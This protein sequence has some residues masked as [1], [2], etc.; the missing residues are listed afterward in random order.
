MRTENRARGKGV[1]TIRGRTGGVGGTPQRSVAQIV[2][3]VVVNP[4][5]AVLSA[6]GLKQQ[7][8]AVAQDANGKPVAGQVFTWSSSL[9]AIASVDQN[10]LATGLAIGSALITAATAG[11]TGSATL[12]IAQTV[13]SVVVSP[14]TAAL[15]AL[16]GTQQLTATAKDASG[17]VI[18]GRSFPWK[19]DNPLVAPVDAG[20]VVKAVGNGTATITATTAGGS[21]D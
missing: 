7:F 6:L 11:V 12:S 9:P 20:G 1:A 13:G 18:P 14:A 17:N 4:A 5:S 2:R 19:S 15:D 10:G 8:T 16:G 21:V 3:A